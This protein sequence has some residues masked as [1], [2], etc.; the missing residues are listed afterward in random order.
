M[1][2]VRSSLVGLFV[3]MALTLILPFSYAQETA[4][5][6]LVPQQVTGVYSTTYYSAFSD[7]E[8]F[9]VLLPML[10]A[11]TH[12]TFPE[13]FDLRAE[14][15][16][17]GEISGDVST[18][19]YQ[20]PLP[21]TP[22][23]A[24]WF[25]T[26]GDPNTTSAVKVFVAGTGNGM[27]GKGYVSRYDFI[28]TRSFGFDPTSHLWNG[29]LLVWA[30]EDNTRFPI[31]NGE[32]NIYYTADDVQIGVPA[33]WSVVEVK[34][35][36]SQESVRVFRTSQPYL[37][38]SEP[39]YLTDVDLSTLSYEDAF[40]ELL[41]NLE[42]T[43]V[44]TDYRHVDWQ[45]LRERYAPMAAQISTDYEFHELLEATLFSFRDGHLAI[46]GPGIPDWFWGWVGMQVYPVDSELMVVETYDV[47]P[48]AF[49]TNIVPGTVIL[50]VN[51]QPA[52]E[53]F[54]SV[55]R[56]VYSGGHETQD[57]WRRGSLAFRGLPGTSYDLTY[58]LPDGT[59]ASA[60]V[61][62]EYIG[63]IENFASGSLAPLDYQIIN[64]NVGVITIRNFTS[65]MLD[66]L[67]DE[68]M[69]VMTKKQVTGIVIDLRSNGGGFSILSNY[70]LGSFLNE[71]IYA[72][73][74]VSALDEDGD[75]VQDIEE[76]YYYGREQIFD[77]ANVMVLIGPDCF[78]ACEF[79]AYAF[80]EIGAQIIGHL[81]SGGAGGGVGAT[82]LLPGGTSI[83]GMG[84]VMSED[85]EGNVIIEGIGVPLDVQVP[86]S[87]QA[88]ANGE[89]SVL[90]TAVQ[91]LTR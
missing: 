71:D 14:A 27:V 26:D 13:R 6:G 37:E 3:F 63:E 24:G 87:V 18:G 21:S 89:D 55:G 91:L 50:T 80:K 65:A 62:T 49:S 43:Y 39:T 8:I 45:S 85:A 22:E 52:M 36:G 48:V 81:T 88:L 46:I 66:N 61:E 84:V 12:L 47:S 77:P 75:G 41:D 68:A 83:Y 74:E 86:F 42:A 69:A 28:Y 79:A 58:R 1:R 16:I 35:K 44:F 57:T 23:A 32:D 5:D 38:L 2:L 56:T 78:S 19:V 64:G 34:A 90:Q 59:L 11:D 17:V 60:T 4:E 20:I 25:D 70:M 51:G 10:S 33:G 76:D 15:Q 53:Y 7:W 54:A 29:K 82:Y 72:G 31:L 30:A 40:L 73:R 9:P 67:W